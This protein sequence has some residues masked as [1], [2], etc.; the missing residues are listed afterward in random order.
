VRSTSGRF[1]HVTLEFPLGNKVYE[2]L[3]LNFMRVSPQGDRVALLEWTEPGKGDVIVVDRSGK[4]TT[5]SRGWVGLFGLAWSRKG[6]EVWFTATRPSLE[7][8]PPAVR[9]V[10]L[11]GKERRDPRS[12]LA[13]PERGVC[14]RACPA[15]EQPCAR[16]RAVP[17]CREATEREMGGSTPPMFRTSPTTERRFCSARGGKPGSPV[18]SLPRVAGGA[19]GA[20]SICAGRMARPPSASAR[21]IRGPCRQTGS[22][23]SCLRGMTRNGPCCPRD[24]G[25]RSISGSVR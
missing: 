10:S 19:P 23:C 25:C 11:S 24:Q 15:R 21:G 8:G 7:E 1:D 3:F 13:V 22:G 18:A 6:D 14:R 2:S 9:A 16:R 4:K 20:P 17:G 12:N 5:L